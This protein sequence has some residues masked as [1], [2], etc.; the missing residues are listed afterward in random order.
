MGGTARSAD[1]WSTVA[2]TRTRTTTVSRG[3][4]RC[5]GPSR[6]GCSPSRDLQSSAPHL[7]QATD[8]AVSR[9]RC[10]HTVGTQN[11]PR[12]AGRGRRPDRR[13]RARRL[14]VGT[15]SRRCGWGGKRLLGGTARVRASLLTFLE[16]LGRVTRALRIESLG[17]RGSGLPLSTSAV[18]L[19]H[20][21]R[22]R[23][24]ASRFWS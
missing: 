15:A 17:L 4:G 12:R 5:S 13:P 16:V 6:L 8:R 11:D 24:C 18:L 19:N 9:C 7:L 20:H 3:L 14:V 22:T 1:R 23:A 10:R 2:R 21:V